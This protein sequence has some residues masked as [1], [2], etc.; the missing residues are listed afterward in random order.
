MP[1]RRALLT[2]ICAAGVAANPIGWAWAQELRPSIFEGSDVGLRDKS[3]CR[4]ILYGTAVSTP[5]L[6]DEG[7]VAALARE[8]AILVPECEMQRAIV[9]PVRGQID[10]SGCDGILAFA[11][12]RGMRFRGHPLV[13]HRQNPDWLE[14]AARSSCDERLITDYVC[15]VVGHFGGRAHSWDVVNEAIAPPDGRPDGLRC[16]FWLETFGPRYID[17]AYQ[18]ARSADPTALLVYNDRGCELGA[19][20][21]DSFRAATLDFLEKA[22]ARD[23]QIGA[24]GLEGHLRAFGAPVDQQKLRAFL[25][26]VKAM[27]L[28]ILVTE[29]DVDDRCGPSDVALRDRAVADASRRFLDVVVDAGAVAIV[30]WGLSDRFLAPPDLRERLAGASPRMLPLDNDLARTPMWC[31]IAEALA[32]S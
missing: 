28:R 21:N 2:G 8:A 4:G 16:S 14:E 22:L 11:E 7:F 24:L 20:A 32:R 29:H 26:E 19:P 27:G 18:A 30:T 15:N 25:A 10:L 17:L 12:S 6:R 9:E 23:V 3:A 31:A 1:S 13:W 5:E